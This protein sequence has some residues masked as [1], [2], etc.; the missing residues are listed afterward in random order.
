[1]RYFKTI[2]TVALSA[3]LTS[4]VTSQESASTLEHMTLKA[5]L[6]AQ[7][8]VAQIVESRGQRAVH[9]DQVAVR[10]GELAGT[11]VLREASRNH[12]GAALVGLQQGERYWLFLDRGQGL[13]QARGGSRGIVRSGPVVSSAIESLLKVTGAS[14]LRV[15]AGHLSSP[16]PRVRK[17]AALALPRMAGLES[18]EASVRAS[19]RTQLMAEF[20][21]GGEGS[22]FVSLL[23]AL[24]RS[25]PQRAATFAWS[26]VADGKRKNLQ[27]PARHL[28][29]RELPAKLT[30]D[31]A[32]APSSEDGAR[33][34]RIASVLV[35]VEPSRALL[36][37]R[38]WMQSTRGMARVHASA[39][40]LALGE[41]SQT[42]EPQ[43]NSR[44]FAAAEQLARSLEQLS[45]RGRR[46]RSIRP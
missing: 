17:D 9:F 33:N 46:Y 32:P 37:A 29:L 20:A 1:M 15:I 27:R 2:L 10:R 14:R 43:L 42:V 40:L 7:A 18:A 30:A 19:I 31:T 11:V 28:L 4:S 22:R 16:D 5:E 21:A 24:K 34:L 36:R 12:C 45:E 39:T 8:R 6:V 41:S 38:T 23:F 25:E 26:L 13:W 3:F 35:T 44:E